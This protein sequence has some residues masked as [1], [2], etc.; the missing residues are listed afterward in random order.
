MATV[1]SIW[2]CIFERSHGPEFFLTPSD[3]LETIMM[4]ID[5]VDLANKFLL[6]VV[7]TTILLTLTPPMKFLYKNQYRWIFARRPGA[8]WNWWLD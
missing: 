8:G 5:E 3:P 6:S 2:Y 1:A 4:D 7:Q